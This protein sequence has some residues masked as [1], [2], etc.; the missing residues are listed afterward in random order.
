MKIFNLPDLGEG[1]PDAEI[2]E[3]YVKVGDTIKIDEPLVSMETAKA[4][5]EVP[6][7]F[8]GVIGK[9]YGHV[10]DVIDTGEPLVE[11]DSDEA[12]ATPSSASS[13]DG[14]TV[15]GKIEVGETILKESATGVTPT[16]TASNTISALPIARALARQLNIDLSKINGSGPQG[17]ITAE[18]VK[19]HAPQSQ[20]KISV[21]L[22]NPEAI[23]G[24]RRTMA[25][26]MAASHAEVAP[27]TLVD[28]AD[29]YAWPE[30][31]DITARI[32]RAISVASH[33]EPALNGWYDG[34]SNAR[35]L[36]ST[37]NLGIAMDSVDGLFVPVIQ[38]ANDL[39]P[40]QIRETVNLYK[41]Q[42]KDRT[43][44]P[45][46]LK[47]PSITLSNFGMFAGRYANPIVVPPMIAIIGTGKIY[48][49]VV[50]RDSN[51]ENHRMIPISITFDHRAATG[52]ETSRFLGAMIADLEKPE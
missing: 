49:E 6:S 29:I 20:E 1:L 46:N 50:Y 45:E 19:A 18:D 3:W 9:L 26:M 52:G 25:K 23:R 51:I 16:S 31:T 10:G 40:K 8:D 32:I 37:V 7:P 39:D 30:K 47:D 12:E 44:A 5:V 14:A 42:V 34:Q 17:Q 11:F 43:I 33:T 27:V 35:E 22:N 13:N 48:T 38:G 28:N 24:A 21:H 4:V 2:H 41:Q 15:A 36:S